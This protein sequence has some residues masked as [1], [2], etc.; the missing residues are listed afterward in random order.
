M[1][2]KMLVEVA[3]EMV[4]I[5]G[6]P[7][8]RTETSLHF[9]ET[10]LRAFGADALRAAFLIG[11]DLA[12]YNDPLDTDRNRLHGM[13]RDGDFHTAQV[14]CFAGLLNA[15]LRAGPVTDHDA[16]RVCEL[17]DSDDP[18][19]RFSGAISV[20]GVPHPKIV[21]S[22]MQWVSAMERE[23]SRA[24]RVMAALALRTL[25]SMHTRSPVQIDPLVQEAL[26]SELEGGEG[27]AAQSIRQILRSQGLAMGDPADYVL[28]AIETGWIDIGGNTVIS[29]PL[30]DH[31]LADFA[32]DTAG[33]MLDFFGI[34][35]LPAAAALLDRCPH[36]EARQS[37]AQV[38]IAADDLVPESRFLAALQAPEMI[39]DSA[40]VQML[41]SDLPVDCF[42]AVALLERRRQRIPHIVAQLAENES[43]TLQQRSFAAFALGMA[44]SDDESPALNSLTAGLSGGEVEQLEGAFYF[45]RF[46]SNAVNAFV[47]WY[48]TRRFPWEDF[49]Q[50]V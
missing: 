16:A 8:S 45:G 27:R 43:I 44:L 1:G 47:D 48:Q 32:R 30:P 33:L 13:M 36:T 18:V 40:C 17:L 12:D 14:L 6:I 31:V 9:C 28:S 39:P 37:A 5:S 25:A 23:P 15:G 29:R 7:R 21:S 10:I 41:L 22:L 20:S 38:I 35:A 3:P 19:Y 11:R 26:A 49:A 4:V 46:R 34:K 42:L 50:I 2:A 24:N